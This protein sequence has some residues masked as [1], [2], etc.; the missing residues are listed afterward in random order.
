M[1]VHNEALDIPEGAPLEARFDSSTG[2]DR[3]YYGLVEGQ[4]KSLNHLIARLISPIPGIA[5]I[6]GSESTGYSLYVVFSNKPPERKKL[7]DISVH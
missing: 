6:E 2:L 4:Y 5:V 1:I 3:T 7:A